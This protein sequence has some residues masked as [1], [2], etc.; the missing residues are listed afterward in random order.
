[1]P[2]RFRCSMCEGLLS[3]ARRKAGTEVACPK[4][5]YEIQV[6]EIDAD[7]GADD[8][9]PNVEPVDDPPPVES[10][11]ARLQQPLPA[12]SRS[13]PHPKL[14]DKPL[15]RPLFEQD[16]IDRLI[17]KVVKDAVPGSTG[18]V[19]PRTRDETKPVPQ[20]AP[21]SV[22]YPGEEG[23]F[24]SRGTVV[25]LGLLMAVLLVLAFATGYMAGR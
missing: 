20:P 5:G 19:D 15:E 12:K 22:L 25:V 1:M 7:L 9:E 16:Q 11:S 14:D 13:S 2:I 8:D 23:V 18:Y 24:I 6:P 17:D 10:R 4:C 3:I 21:Q